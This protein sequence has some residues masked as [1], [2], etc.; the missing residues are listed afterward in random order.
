MIRILSILALGVVV[1]LLAGCDG[2]Q[3]DKPVWEGIKIG[4]LAPSDDGTGPGDR[5]LKTINFDVFIFEIPSE[6]MGT[7]DDLWQKVYT[8]P[9]QFSDYDAFRASSFLAGFG[10][11]KVWNE[12]AGLLDAAGARKV[13]TVSLLLLPGQNGDVAVAGLY[14]EQEVYFSRRGSMEGV[15]VGPGRLVLRIG[16]DRIGGSRG[17]CSVTVVPVLS[18]PGRTYLGAGE[19]WGDFVFDSVGFRLKMSPGDFVFLGPE[20]YCSD[21]VNLG[22][23]FFSRPGPV[24]VVRAFL[25]LCTGVNY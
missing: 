10:Q 5:V 6:N 4:D 14:R 23:L 12:V 19:K 8:R 15:T 22:S 17:V 20:K 9:L 11:I 25:L 1:T 16:A 7:F 18:R 24:P 21:R 2:N 13:N 3:S